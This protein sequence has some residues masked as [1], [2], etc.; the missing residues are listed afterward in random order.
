MTRLAFCASTRPI[1]ISLGWF[2]ASCTAGFVIS[3]KV[4]RCMGVCR[5]FSLRY[6]PIWY[7]IASPSR[8]GSAA[9]TMA[10]ERF[11]S[12]VSSLS[13]SALPRTV[14]YSGSKSCSISIAMRDLGKS[15][16]WPFEASTLK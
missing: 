2:I 12:S 13:F 16:T 10:L 4:T 1:L 11:A 8:S 15:I 9:S 5:T 6:L 7:A 3:L 14:I